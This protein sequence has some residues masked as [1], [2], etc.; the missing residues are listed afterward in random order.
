M[1]YWFVEFYYHDMWWPTFSLLLS[2]SYLRGRHRII[3]DL[4]HNFTLTGKL[5][6]IYDYIERDSASLFF[7]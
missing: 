2:L 6:Q 1:I 3:L 7:R 5:F 4:S